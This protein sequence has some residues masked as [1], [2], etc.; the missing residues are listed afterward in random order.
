MFL[1]KTYLGP[2]EI[3][4]TGVFAAEFIPKGKRVFELELEVDH[5]IKVG[6]I[7]KLHEDTR[8]DIL[9]YGYSLK[10]NNDYYVLLYGN[11][12]YTNH[13]YKP[14]TWDNEYGVTRALRDIQIWEEITD[15]YTT[16]MDPFLDRQHLDHIK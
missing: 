7:G 1:V 4:W 6:K 15:N 10:G 5:L 12:R 3:N 16:Y 13:S 9:N 8:R 11:D 14:N 2:S